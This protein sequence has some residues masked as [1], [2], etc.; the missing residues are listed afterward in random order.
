MVCQKW[1]CKAHGTLTGSD[2]RKSSNFAWS[3]RN[4]NGFNGRKWQ[5]MH[6]IHLFHNKTIVDLCLSIHRVWLPSNL[7][8]ID[9]CSA[10]VNMTF[11]V[12][13]WWLSPSAIIQFILGLANGCFTYFPP[14]KS[15]N[16]RSFILVNKQE[17]AAVI[18]EYIYHFLTTL[19]FSSA[20]YVCAG[21][22][23]LRNP[24]Q[25]K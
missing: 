20:Q 16:G 10:S 3:I 23:I 15:F 1:R 13:W 24:L 21:K 2:V 9:L 25:R 14:V 17:Q 12:Q 11:T 6:I 4:V 19:W 5:E 18:H 8:H 22:R 7:N